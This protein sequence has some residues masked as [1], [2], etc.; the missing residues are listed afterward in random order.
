M[1]VVL[2]LESLILAL[3]EQERVGRT[4]YEGTKYYDPAMGTKGLAG[5]ADLYGQRESIPIDVEKYEAM[6]VPMLERSKQAGMQKFGMVPQG[7]T[8]AE[9]LQWQR[10]LEKAGLNP[11]GGGEPKPPKYPGKQVDDLSAMIDDVRMNPASWDEDGNMTPLAAAKYRRLDALRDK[12]VS[13]SLG[14]PRADT[15]SGLY[16]PR[17]AAAQAEQDRMLMGLPS[18]APIV[19]T[20]LDPPPTQAPGASKLD[21]VITPEQD[22]EIRAKMEERKRKK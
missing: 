12:Q 2:V 3:E 14:R 15:P 13:G 16:R 22:A 8:R 20:T 18:S 4:G 5:E 1:R 10:D 9:Y 11:E 19:S 6:T 21:S 17:S 7:Q